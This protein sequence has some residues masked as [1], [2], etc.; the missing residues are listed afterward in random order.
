MT[1]EE[2]TLASLVVIGGIADRAILG[3]RFW[4]SQILVALVNNALVAYYLFP[5]DEKMLRETII[6]AQLFV[7]E[8]KRFISQ[9]QAIGYTYAK[10]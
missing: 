9:R 1:D 7:S 5:N 2:L 3:K 10:L 4:K 8:V 6:V